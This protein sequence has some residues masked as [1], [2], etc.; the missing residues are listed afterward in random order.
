MSLFA[1]KF[2][3]KR[4]LVCSFLYRGQ[5]KFVLQKQRKD[6]VLISCK[7][8]VVLLVRNRLFKSVNDANGCL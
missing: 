8:L 3:N 7:Q 5:T 4:A 6:A 1:D 2:L